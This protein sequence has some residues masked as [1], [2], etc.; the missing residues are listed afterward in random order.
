MT[1]KGCENVNN[2]SNVAIGG[3]GNTT[4]QIV[5]GGDTTGGPNDPKQISFVVA[6]I[7]SVLMRYK[8]RFFC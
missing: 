2:P 5:D 3:H 8:K 6:A 7:Y 4:L 1:V